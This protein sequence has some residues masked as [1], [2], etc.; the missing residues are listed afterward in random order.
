MVGDGWAGLQCHVFWFQMANCSRKTA[1]P[2][3]AGKPAFAP[4][5]RIRHVMNFFGKKKTESPPVAAP[6]AAP[7]SQGQGQGIVRVRETI[8]TTEKREEHIQRK[9]NGE[10]D[11]AKKN[12]QKGDKRSAM[13]CIK[14]KKMYEKQLDQL[15]AAK[16]TLMQQ[17]IALEGMTTNQQIL[18]ANKAAAVEMQA[19]VNAMGGVDGIDGVMDKVDDALTDANEIGEA[20]ARNVD[21]RRC[22]Q[23]LLI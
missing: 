17:L 15:Q 18:E 6:P 16:M 2:Q 22:H 12:M 13:Q 5:A 20:L 8:E 7:P 4:G 21:V 9:I 10:T 14:R 11:Q 23:R 1:F 19:G 3:Q